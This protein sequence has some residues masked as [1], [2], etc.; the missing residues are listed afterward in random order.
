MEGGKRKKLGRW[1][2]L[3]SNALVG[4]STWFLGNSTAMLYVRALGRGRFASL[5]H[6]CVCVCACPCLSA[7]SISVLF[8]TVRL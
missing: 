7:E 2:S 4:N 1:D 8:M 3:S 5:Q 6:M